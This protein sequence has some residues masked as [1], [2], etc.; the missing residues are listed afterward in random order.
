MDWSPDGQNILIVTGTTNP[1][2][3]WAPT[4]LEQIAVA[5]GRRATLLGPAAEDFY[6]ARRYTRPTA[7]R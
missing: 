4:N 7:I 2:F 6:S 1:N 5:D 3:R